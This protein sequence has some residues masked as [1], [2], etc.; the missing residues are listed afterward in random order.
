MHGMISFKMKR[1]M[2]TRIILIYVIL[3]VLSIAL[4]EVFITAAVRDRREED[5]KRSLVV[6]LGLLEEIVPFEQGRIDDLCS[7]LKETT[8]AR[9]TVIR[10]DGMVIG[11]SDTDSSQ[12]ENHAGRSE[13]VEALLSATGISVRLSETTRRSTAGRSPSHR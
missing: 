3:T 9:I 11:D 12:M 4:I 5:L 6:Q 2:L 7:R 13:I 8:G 10:G 1:D